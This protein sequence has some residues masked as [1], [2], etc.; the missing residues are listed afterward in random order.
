[1]TMLD[2]PSTG[3]LSRRQVLALL[4]AFGVTRESLAQDP[5]TADPRAFRV[6][7][8]NERVRVLEFRS[9]PGLGVCG[10]GMHYHPTRVMISLT[11]AKY[12]V[13]NPQGKI[14]V[15]EVAPGDVLFAEAVTH[16]TE[17][18]GGT[19]ARTYIIELKDQDWKPSTG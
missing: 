9:R 19:G 12:K 7:L 18:I 13:T 10:Q 16:S 4:T 11:G 6:V 15:R 5:R 2:E 8:E 17:N 1:M 3:R 14:V